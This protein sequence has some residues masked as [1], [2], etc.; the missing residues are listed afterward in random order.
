M[1]NA[2][3]RPGDDVVLFR[4]VTGLLLAAALLRIY[5]WRYTGRTWE[6]ALI[7]VLHAE[8]FWQG[9]GLTHVKPGE[10]P[11]HGFTSPISVLIP[12][13]AGFVNAAWG[14]ALQKAASVVAA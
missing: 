14:L 13:A 12:L 4:L 10:P 8:N 11:L 2:T 9:L 1:S 3:R 5:F 6:D 7:T